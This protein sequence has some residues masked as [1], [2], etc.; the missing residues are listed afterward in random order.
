VSDPPLTKSGTQLRP[1]FLVAFGGIALGLV[2]A[3]LLD[4]FHVPV[5][6]PALV[7]AVLGYVV[8]LVGTFLFAA[9]ASSR[10]RQRLE[11]TGVSG[12][13]RL[14]SARQTGARVNN[15]PVVELTLDVEV[16]GRPPYRVRHQEVL[17]LESAHKLAPGASF[18]AR[19]DRADPLIL[20]VQI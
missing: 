17:G 2:T 13:A 6:K 11:Q 16:P 18:D 14:V 7:V 3:R 4:A 10:A 1:V 15:L 9:T 12:R 8:V 20:S 19:V 5:V